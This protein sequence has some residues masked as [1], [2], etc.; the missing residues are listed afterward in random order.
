MFLTPDWCWLKEEKREEERGRH[1]RY[2]GGK[3]IFLLASCSGSA[4]TGVLALGDS[5]PEIQGEG[6]HWT[7]EER[8]L[9]GRELLLIADLARFLGVLLDSGDTELLL[10]EGSSGG[11][12]GGGADS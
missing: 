2:G 12:A 9:F 10:V 11:F 1:P 8:K 7:E 6:T 3:F 5:L 4:R